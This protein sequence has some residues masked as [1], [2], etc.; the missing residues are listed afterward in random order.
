MTRR[1]L[2]GSTATGLIGSTGIASAKQPAAGETESFVLTARPTEPEG[3]HHIPFEVP[4]GVRR[5]DFEVSKNQDGESGSGLAISDHRGPQHQSDGF[6]GYLGGGETT[7]YI[8]ATDASPSF[9][10]GQIE[11]GTWTVMIN[12]GTQTLATIAVRVTLTYGRKPQVRHPSSRP[13]PPQSKEAGWYS[14]DLHVHTTSSPDARSS[15]SALSPTEW[16]TTA[17][18]NDLDFV[19]LT[20][21]FV[22]VQNRKRREAMRSTNEDVLLLGGNEFTTSYGHAT[23]TGL[24]S[25]EWIDFRVRPTGE[26]LRQHEA[27]LQQFVETTRRY[28]AY[29]SAAHPMLYP[30]DDGWEF[31]PDM[32]RNPAARLDGIEVWNGPWTPDDEAALRFWDRLLQLGWDVTANGG[33]DTHETENATFGQLPGH[34][35]THV[36][37]ESLSTDAIVDGLKRGKAWISA[38]PNG[39]ELYLRGNVNDQEA[40]IGDTLTAPRSDVATFEAV[41][42]GGAGNTL[43]FVRDGQVID[44]AQIQVEE[45]TVSTTQPVGNAGYVRLKLRGEPNLQP[46]APTQSR[47]GMQALTNP[48]FFKPASESLR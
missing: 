10:P 27:R 25:G 29:T 23:V 30:L 26:P 22:V 19:S 12:V 41:V 18:K 4:E 39:P 31:F 6:R 32:L 11:A 20:D 45:T 17:A 46:D 7:C 15:G 14:G 48:I 28:G 2:L 8:T 16:V 13:I 42:R 3:Y 38:T 40:T 36:Y 37:A 21:H 44:T 43:L 34:P 24:D 1:K 35:T 33:S 5:I 9:T 47:G